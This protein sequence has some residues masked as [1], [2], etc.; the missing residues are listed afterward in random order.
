MESW[1]EKDYTMSIVAQ[2]IFPRNFRRSLKFEFLFVWNLFRCP[3]DDLNFSPFNASANSGSNLS[4]MYLKNPY[5]FG[6]MPVDPLHSMGY[7]T[8]RLGQW[9]C[10]KVSSANPALS[11]P[12]I[13]LMKRRLFHLTRQFDLTRKRDHVCIKGKCHSLFLCTFHKRK[14]SQ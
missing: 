13:V 12:A 8:G 5:N 10:W 4:P 9:R 2:A 3:S 14:S 11:R 1:W 7:Q 6:I